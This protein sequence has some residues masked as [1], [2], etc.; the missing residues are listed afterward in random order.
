MS[1]VKFLAVF[2]LPALLLGMTLGVVIGQDSSSSSPIS[3]DSQAL[4]TQVQRQVFHLVARY[5]Y[6]EVDD[7]TAAAIR[8]ELRALSKDESRLFLDFTFVIQK[9]GFSGDNWVNGEPLVPL[10][11]QRYVLSLIERALY[12]DAANNAA[13][14]Q[15]EAEIAALSKDEHEF[16]TE[17]FDAIQHVGLAGEDSGYLPAEFVE[18]R[19]AIL[20][21]MEKKGVSSFIDIN[22]S[23]DELREVLPKKPSSTQPDAC[24]WPY[25]SCT[26]IPF[27]TQ[28]WRAA[29]SSPGCITGSGH[30]RVTEDPSGCE[31]WN[32]DYR[33]WFYTPWPWYGI[34]GTTTNADCIADR[35]PHAAWWSNRTEME[36]GYG[37]VTF[38]CTIFDGNYLASIMRVSP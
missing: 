37:T 35:G 31:F 25:V 10:P 15:L 24:Y 36:F 9:L 19:K 33:V 27:T 6:D 3:A 4:P 12:D 2:A 17:L 21:I 26:Y 38:T 30:D 5:M 18:I 8:D 32:C 20:Y 14:R 22:L 7:A 29:C 13:S 1:K 16:Y 23:E 34:D 11:R 28:S